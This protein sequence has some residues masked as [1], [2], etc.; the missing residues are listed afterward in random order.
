[1][2]PSLCTAGVQGSDR[3]YS[4]PVHLRMI[5]FH[6]NPA[7][8]RYMGPPLAKSSIATGRPSDLARILSLVLVLHFCVFTVLAS[9]ICA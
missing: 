7:C 9:T 1:M 2:P 4:G 5:S 6:C 3:T 8:R